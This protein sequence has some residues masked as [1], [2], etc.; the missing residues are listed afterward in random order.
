MQLLVGLKAYR[1]K[2]VEEH[3]KTTDDI[4]ALVK[5]GS[6]VYE[7]EDERHIVSAGDGALFQANVPG[8]KRVLEPVTLFLFR[9]KSDAPLFAHKKV[10]F[11]DKLRIRS[12]INL[13]EQAEA[14]NPADAFEFRQSLFCDIVTQ[15]R[16]QNMNLHP[17]QDELISGAVRHINKHIGEK[18]DLAQIA[19]NCNLSYPQFIRRFKSAMQMTPSDYVASV[20]LNKAKLLL[21]DAQ[22]PIR[23]IAFLCGFDSEYYFSKFFKKRI[24]LAP[25]TYKKHGNL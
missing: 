18:L 7:T 6:F 21:N 13:L 24:G 14:C 2:F 8:Y 17:V 15:Y 25:S 4:F 20:R 22:M 5:S 12:T 1:E 19:K 16:L 11:E 10:V 23:E 3:F 9:Y